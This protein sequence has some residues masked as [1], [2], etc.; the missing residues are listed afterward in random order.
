[1]REKQSW[2][3]KY[4]LWITQKNKSYNFTWIPGL[5]SMKLKGQE[6][7]SIG[8]YSSEMELEEE[9]S[10]SAK[11]EQHFAEGS[12][13]GHFRQASNKELDRVQHQI[14]WNI[15]ELR[16]RR[17]CASLSCPAAW[18]DRFMN[19]L[20]GH[21]LWG[22]KYQHIPLIDHHN[23]V[24][25]TNQKQV[26]VLIHV[27]KCVL[28]INTIIFRKENI[29]LGLKKTLMKYYISLINPHKLFNII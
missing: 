12:R 24:S 6:Q 27:V 15:I 20:I 28:Q 18:F 26:V 29:I 19:N 8:T 14:L 5:E 23:L 4:Y 22:L 21:H 1:M 25:I 11:E 3:K 13:T 17:T 2:K 16:R 7:K 9:D 10:D